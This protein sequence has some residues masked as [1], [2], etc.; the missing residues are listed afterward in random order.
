VYIHNDTIT[1]EKFELDLSMTQD[2][3]KYGPRKN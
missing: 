1:N 2:R 3:F